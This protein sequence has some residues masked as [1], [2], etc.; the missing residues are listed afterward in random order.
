M[1]FSLGQRAAAEF[2]SVATI[3][4]VVLGTGFMATNLGADPISGL[5]VN[6][7][8]TAAALFVLITVFAPV[9]GAHFNPIVTLI[10]VLKKLTSL[11]EGL[12]YLAAQLAGGVLG[13][14]MAN[15]MFGQAGLSQSDVIRSGSGQWLGEV[16]ASFGLVLLILMLIQNQNQHLIPSAVALWITAGYFFTAS[17]SFANPAVTFGRTFSEAGSSIS[18]SSLP[19]FV[20]MQ[21]L[22]ALLALG[23]FQMFKPKERETK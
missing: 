18:I 17:S 12:S 1:T 7:I 16:I 3:V 20:L 6:A 21:I 13:A 22:G 8:A 15:L 10:F 4:A 5:L 23:V 2:G 11:R 9:S 14:L 19:M